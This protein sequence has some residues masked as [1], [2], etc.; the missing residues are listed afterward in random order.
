MQKRNIVVYLA[1]PMPSYGLFEP[2][3]QDTRKRLYS[4]LDEL[5]SL[6]ESLLFKVPDDNILIENPSIE[7]LDTEE[8][9]ILSEV[10]RYFSDKTLELCETI[11]FSSL[12][13]TKS[14]IYKTE[15]GE[16]VEFNDDDFREFLLLIFNLITVTNICKF[17]VLEVRDSAV[18]VDNE[19]QKYSKFPEVTCTS[20]Q[21]A[22]FIAK[23]LSWPDSG[24]LS[25]I[26]AWQWGIKRGFFNEGLDGSSMG[27]ALNAFTRLFEFSENDSSM[28]MMWS[29]I[30]IEALYVSGRYSIIDQVRE[31]VQMILG[32][33]KHLRKII[34]DMYDFRSRF[35]HGDLTFPAYYYLSDAH[36]KV[37]KFYD[38]LTES[39]AISVAILVA[40][41]QSIIKKDWS[42]LDFK[43]IVSDV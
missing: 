32:K 43:F 23:S 15:S 35:V 28:T 39:T 22:F 6:S 10:K 3:N 36:E 34:N 29:M 1:I 19:L 40:T 16:N 11:R 24:Q 20:I 26:D 4:A 31:K 7:L 5:C 2:E 33:N 42:G 37:E 30:G 41:F 9:D 25:I 13:T 18:L 8:P 14:T 12:A 38:G 21:H 17:G 27:R